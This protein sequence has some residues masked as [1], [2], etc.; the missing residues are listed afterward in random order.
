[1]NDSEASDFPDGVNPVDIQAA[2]HA[3]SGATDGQEI[4]ADTRVPVSLATQRLRLAVAM[5]GGVSLAVWMGGVAREVNLLTQ[6]SD[7]RIRGEGETRV[8]LSGAPPGSLALRVRDLYGQL[9]DLVDMTAAVDVL[10]GTSAGGINAAVLGLANARRLDLGTLRD[11]WL[12]AGAFDQLLQD[13]Q[14]SPSPTSLLKGD[15]HLLSAL[16]EGLTDLTTASSGTT[17]KNLARETTVHITTTLLHGQDGRF[18]DDYGNSVTD[19]DNHGLFTF[20]KDQLVAPEAVGALALAARSSAS[21]PGAFEPSFVPIGD[22]VGTDEPKDMQGWHPDMSAY[23][24]NIAQSTWAVDGGLLANRPIGPLLQSVLARTTDREVRRAMLFVVPTTGSPPPPV[25]PTYANPYQ[26]GESLK[27]DLDAMLNQS[28]AADLDAIRRHND[29]V[30]SLASARLLLARLAGT[31]RLADEQTWADYRSV[32]ATAIALP[33]VEA[34]TA[35]MPAASGWQPLFGTGHRAADRIRTAV[36]GAVK[37]RLPVPPQNLAQVIALSLPAYTKARAV[38]LDLIRAGYQLA[39][40]DEDV[41]AIASAHKQLNTLS[42]MPADLASEIADALAGQAQKEPPAKDASQG[43][44]VKKGAWDTA[45]NAGNWDEALQQLATYLLGQLDQGVTG[46]P[47]PTAPRP[48]GDAQQ[49][50]TSAPAPTVQ[51]Q[52]VLAQAWDA[53]LDALAAVAVITRTL[54]DTVPPRPDGTAAQSHTPGEVTDGA[55]PTG[56]GT[57]GAGGQEPLPPSAAAV[58]RGT[59]AQNTDDHRLALATLIGD[60]LTFL[61]LPL[62]RQES[63]DADAGRERLALRLAE[64]HAAERS[65]SPI[66][67]Q[68]E[69]RLELIQASAE[70]RTLLDPARTSAADKLTGLQLHHFAAFYKG[71]WRANDWMWGRLDGA[72][73]LVQL[74][75]DPRRIKAVVEAE[76][77]RPGTPAPKNGAEWFYAKLCRIVGEP[78]PEARGLG[79]T[80]ASILKDLAFIDDPGTVVPPSLPHVALWAALPLQRYIAAEEVTAVASQ[81]R[82][83][84]NGD[85]RGPALGWL[86]DYDKAL[87]GKPSGNQTADFLEPRN[88]Y[89]RLVEAK[90]PSGKRIDTFLGSLETL[91]GKAPPEVRTE[92]EYLR[93]SE[94]YIPPA[95]N[96][97]QSWAGQKFAAAARDGAQR[98]VLDEAWVNRVAGTLATCPI[99]DERIDGEIGTPLFTRT[100]TQALAVATA[101]GTTTSDKPPAT[102]APA[103]STAR[104]VTTA[105]YLVTRGARAG[106]KTLIWL[107][108]L[109]LGV[110]IASMFVTVPI[111]GT[112]GLAV[113]LVGAILLGVGLWRRSIYVVGLVIALSIALIAAAPWLPYLHSHLFSWLGTTALPFME[114]HAWVWTALFLLVLLPPVWMLAGEFTRNRLRRKMAQQK[115]EMTQQL[116][117]ARSVKTVGRPG[118]NG[119]DNTSEP[120]A[121]SSVTPLTGTALIPAGTQADLKHLAAPPSDS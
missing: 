51:G 94:Q 103:F 81:I 84:V 52:E 60:Y 19:A 116:R 10:S 20:T 29:Q 73:W 75:L 43:S 31:G 80:E 117:D 88:I 118:S 28:I 26:L 61:R 115:R 53:L 27:L 65:T 23:A 87:T 86:D 99:P 4:L 57:S 18:T 77:E 89:G 11:L 15:R 110:G 119:P 42:V 48:P 109:A 41:V 16:R 34:L 25:E 45:L 85:P 70:T 6:G 56:P 32:E 64:L 54:A 66:G 113:L 40:R 97:L 35:R 107:G 58:T 38:V 33:I 17:D 50:G 106:A 47:A 71:T 37:A 30:T 5:T 55:D 62:P 49:A 69:Q 91:L 105:A 93:K 12:R 44:A 2:D 63:D 46:V 9:L 101:A 67:T 79:I 90:V 1:M 78:G 39:R 83:P 68:A 96:A 120:A 102:L 8:P 121:A 24:D 108:L 104:T 92:L 76:R 72:G 100:V 21:F 3:A 22:G 111:V 98:P 7:L 14:A 114:H 59:S 95:L 74:L 112:A 82:N 36:V 13:P